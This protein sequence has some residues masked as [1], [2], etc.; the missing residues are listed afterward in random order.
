MANE[1]QIAANRRNAQRST[2]PRTSA[3]K[4]RAKKNA[5]RHGLAAEAPPWG[6][7]LGEIDRSARH[8]A[9]RGAS[10][11]ALSFARTVAEAV[12]EIARVRE[13]KTAVIELV[14]RF[15]YDPHSGELPPQMIPAVDALPRRSAEA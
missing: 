5:Y 13:T 9:G 8:I 4:T 3:G 12:F 7:S 1:R 14:R 6:I 2:G 10:A 11:M 15:G